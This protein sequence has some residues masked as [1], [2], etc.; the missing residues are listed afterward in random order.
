[1]ELKLTPTGRV[2][3]AKTIAEYQKTEREK[4]RNNDEYREKLK[5]RAREQIGRAV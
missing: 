2:S 5:T 1:M 4:Y 3:K